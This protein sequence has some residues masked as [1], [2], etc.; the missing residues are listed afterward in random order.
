MF[1]LTFVVAIAR[2]AARLHHGVVEHHT[3]QAVAG[4]LL[5]FAAIWWAWMNYT[6]FASADDMLYRIL[7]MVQM[8]DRPCLSTI[9]A[10]C[11]EK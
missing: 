10:N 6:R 9:R 7:T 8:G 3:A 2:A 4:Y 1:D 11:G 5:A